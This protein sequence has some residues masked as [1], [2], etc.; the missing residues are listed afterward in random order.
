MKWLANGRSLPPKDGDEWRV[1]FG[2]FEELRVAGQE[3]VPHPAWAWNAH[4][5]DDTHRPEQ[6]TRVR[7]SKEELR[8]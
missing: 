6:F 7:F 8:F 3:V 2:R 5:I 1:F 4:G